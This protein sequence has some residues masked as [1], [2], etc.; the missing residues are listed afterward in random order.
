MN[1]L[2]LLIAF[3]GGVVAFISPCV[4]PMIPVYLVILAGPE[5]LDNSSPVSRQVRLSIFKHAVAFIAGFSII[6]T[7]LGFIAGISGNLI[8]PESPVIRY[9]SGFIFFVL[10]TFM[11]AAIRFP[12]LNLERRIHL[13]AGRQGLL[14]SFVTGTVFTLAWTPCVTPVLGSILTLAVGG[15]DV[16]YSTGLLMLFSLGMGIPLLIIAFFAGTAL[17]AIRRFK[18]IFI[19]LYAAGGLVLV[20]TGLLILTGKLNL[21]SV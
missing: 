3:G 12:Q 15:T 18:G 20:L 8:S 11:L 17:S 19:W 21:L 1:D 14:R 13:P 7:G 2:N 16:Y 6:F 10:G 4:L 5:F 9:I